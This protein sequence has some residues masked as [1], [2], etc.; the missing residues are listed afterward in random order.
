MTAEELDDRIVFPASVCLERENGFAQATNLSQ[1]AFCDSAGSS[2][3]DENGVAE[4][5]NQPIAQ[6]GC[7]PGR[8]ILCFIEW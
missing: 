8:M 2:I 5:D 1:N 6:P 3:W 4:R 7:V